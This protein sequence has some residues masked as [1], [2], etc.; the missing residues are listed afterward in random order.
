MYNIFSKSPSNKGKRNEPLPLENDGLPDSYRPNGLCPRCNKQSSFEILG[1]LPITYTD[2]I[3][4]TTGERSFRDRVSSLLCRNCNQAIAVIEEEYIGETPSR[5]KMESGGYVTFRG[6]HWWP[7][8]DNNLSKD[9]PEGIREAFCEA[10]TS[11]LI[12]CPRASTVMLRRTLE[13]ITDNLGE[14]KGRLVDR[15]KALSDKGILQPSL[16]E[17][18][19]EVRLIGNDGAHYDPINPVTVDDAKQLLGFMRELLK[20]LYELPAELNRRRSKT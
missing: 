14:T 20:Y 13:A 7:F 10:A 2:F 1:S 17:W 8:P 18:A 3:S 11:M 16:S 15:L 4:G 9:I 6:I 19:K 12:N 5:V